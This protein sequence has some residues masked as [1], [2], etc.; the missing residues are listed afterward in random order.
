MNLAK[1]TGVF[2]IGAATA[3]FVDLIK[4]VYIHQKPYPIRRA[5]GAISALTVL[6]T[7]A[8]AISEAKPSDESES[9]AYSGIVID[10]KLAKETCYCEP[11][12]QVR[13]YAKGVIGALSKE[14]AMKFCPEKYRRLLKVLEE[15]KENAK[16]SEIQINIPKREK[17]HEV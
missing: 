13:C 11:I 6:G 9:E 14:Q 16:G 4:N 3:I 5:V 12:I 10:E 8:Y 17:V 1:L 15:L 7:I 2:S